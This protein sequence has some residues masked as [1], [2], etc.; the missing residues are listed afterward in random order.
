[1]PCDPINVGDVTGI[2]CTR[3]QRIKARCHY[4]D[5]PAPFL[6]DHPVIRKGKRGTC[7]TPMCADCR[8]TIGP[9]QDLCRPHFNL[10]RNNGNKFK[11]GDVEI[12]A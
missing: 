11:L 12:H 9:D 10:W 8:N 4:C 6:C 1:M 3:G 2:V 7:D 5:R